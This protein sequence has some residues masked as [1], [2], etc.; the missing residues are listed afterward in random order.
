M[1]LRSP[2][3]E[4]R[5]DRGGS[6]N[7]RGLAARRLRCQS[8]HGRF[9]GES[10]LCGEGGSSGLEWTCGFMRLKTER[11]MGVRGLERE[12]VSEVEVGILAVVVKAVDGKVGGIK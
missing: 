2:K 3:A 11:L 6:G 8:G 5:R 12:Y 9:G 4:S 10:L 1:A 7:W